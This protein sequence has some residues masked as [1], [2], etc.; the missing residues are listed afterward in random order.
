MALELRKEKITHGSARKTAIVNQP[1]ADAY[2]SG[3]ELNGRDCYF[4]CREELNKQRT[5]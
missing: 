5:I 2:S 1:G 4:I 3:N